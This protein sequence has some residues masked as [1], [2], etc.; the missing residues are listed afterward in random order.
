VQNTT[1]TPAV[2][3][4]LSL[5]YLLVLPESFLGTK[6]A[7]L[8]LTGAEK[9]RFAHRPVREMLA[10]TLPGLF[11]SMLGLPESFTGTSVS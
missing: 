7:A 11:A 2:L 10:S 3:Y 8:A 5:N 1:L 6:V 9:R 4:S